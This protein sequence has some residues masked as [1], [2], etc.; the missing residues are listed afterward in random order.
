MVSQ[1]RIRYSKSRFT[2]AFERAAPAVRTMRPM[3]S[4]TSSSTAISLRRFRSAA[5]VIFREMPPP[6]PVLGI[7]TV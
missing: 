2:S 7:S 6:R 5:L 3:P 4:G 1:S